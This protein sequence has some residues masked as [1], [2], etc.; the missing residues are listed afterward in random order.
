MRL[1]MQSALAS[2]LLGTAVWPSPA[3]A[4]FYSAKAIEGRVV[5]ASGRPLEGVLIVANW[6]L[7][8]GLDTGIPRGHIQILETTTDAS[9]A[10]RLPSWGPRISF[11]GH[12]SSRWP[13]IIAF[14]SGYRYRESTAQSDWNGM[15]IPLTPLPDLVQYTKMF[16]VL[17][18]DIDII[19]VR[20]GDTCA[21]RH[22]SLTVQIMSAEAQRLRALGMR[23]FR[24]FAE[25][26]A[27]KEDFFSKQG[28]GSAK[29]FLEGSRK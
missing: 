3:R 13:H 28:C 18:R 9:G 29:E 14:K 15:T 27:I 20:S 26:L 4:F 16:D 5:D 22:L 7:E 21:W 1:V 24:D 25:D 17:N 19:A 6:L 12:A 8:G 10:F 11:S 2:L 23:G